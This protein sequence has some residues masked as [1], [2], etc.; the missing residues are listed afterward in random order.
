[1]D[2]MRWYRAEQIAV[3]TPYDGTSDVEKGAIRIL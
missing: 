1:M 3:P 2:V